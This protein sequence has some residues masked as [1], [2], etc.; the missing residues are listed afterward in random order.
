[1]QGRSIV[2]RISARFVGESPLVYS[3]PRTGFVKNIVHDPPLASSQIEPCLES[4]KVIHP[5]QVAHM[6]YV[7]ILLL[8]YLH[9]HENATAFLVGVFGELYNNFAIIYDLKFS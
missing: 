8:T 5:A 2:P 4:V 1:M 3:T 6:Y 7:F 9:T